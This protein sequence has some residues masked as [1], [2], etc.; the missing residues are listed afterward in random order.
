LAFETALTMVPGLIAA[1]RWLAAVY[2][3]PGGDLTKAAEHRKIFAE[4]RRQREA[5][6]A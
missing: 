3:L 2:S 4:L 1:H 6:A 5:Q